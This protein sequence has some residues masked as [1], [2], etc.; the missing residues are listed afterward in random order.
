MRQY[1]PV[2]E[3]ELEPQGHILLLLVDPNRRPLER[4]YA[5]GA[6]LKQPDASSVNEMVWTSSN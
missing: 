3:S 5:S 2:A 6:P 1:Q 4:H